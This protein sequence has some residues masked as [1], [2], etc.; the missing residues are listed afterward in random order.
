MTE[1]Y[2]F[3]ADNWRNDE[4][5]SALASELVSEGIKLS[6]I[7][8]GSDLYPLAL[9]TAFTFFSTQSSGRYTDRT[10]MTIRRIADKWADST[11][12]DRDEHVSTEGYLPNLYIAESPYSWDEETEI[13][14]GGILSILMC[15]PNDEGEYRGL[16]AVTEQIRRRNLG[17]SMMRACSMFNGRMSWYIHQT[18]FAGMALATDSGFAPIQVNS[19]TG[20]IQYGIPAARRNI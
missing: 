12:S 16:L 20:T 4:C 14:R 17:R 18:N 11:R 10:M 1:T 8:F 3:A 15:L 2:M 13:K 5:E 19:N 6:Y 7:D 9:S